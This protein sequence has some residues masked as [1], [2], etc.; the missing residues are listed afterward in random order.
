M[1][2]KDR[3]DSFRTA[4]SIR[5]GS[6][7]VKRRVEGRGVVAI[8]PVLTVLRPVDGPIDGRALVVVAPSSSG[9]LLAKIKRTT[10][11]LPCHAAQ[12]NGGA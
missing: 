9:G 6:A 10:S 7:G 2:P 12:C 11:T 8:L 5:E 4:D 1:P 3:M